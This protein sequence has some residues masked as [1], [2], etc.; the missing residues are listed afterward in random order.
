MATTRKSHRPS[1]GSKSPPARPLPPRHVPRA[2]IKS[3]VHT[4][5]RIKPPAHPVPKATTQRT[6]VTTL[7]APARSPTEEAVEL[8]AGDVESLPPS[9][10]PLPRLPAMPPTPKKQSLKPQT[11][12]P[13]MLP[14]VEG[15][16]RVKLLG[17]LR[18]ALISWASEN[19]YSSSLKSVLEDVVAEFPE[20]KDL[21][22]PRKTHHSKHAG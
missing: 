12:L 16:E 17:L 19:A 18:Y 21:L 8:K 4:A 13:P 3:E 20:L 14:I 22:H 5:P 10:P 1:S 7:P 11:L 9:Q 15:G 2:A 6:R